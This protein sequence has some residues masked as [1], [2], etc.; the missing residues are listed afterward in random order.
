MA[1]VIRAACSASQR[2]F[3]SG[4]VSGNRVASRPSSSLTQLACAGAT[5]SARENLFASITRSFAASGVIVSVYGLMQSLGFCQITLWFCLVRLCLSYTFSAT[6]ANRGETKEGSPW[7]PLYHDLN[8]IYVDSYRKHRVRHANDIYDLDQAWS[9]LYYLGV[10]N[11]ATV[12]STELEL[13][14]LLHQTPKCMRRL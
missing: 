10:F 1:F 2:S 7:S 5:A 8:V 4:E 6:I 3:A 14:L 13:G 11:P 12:Y 9:V